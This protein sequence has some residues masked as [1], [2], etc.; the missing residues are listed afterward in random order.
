LIEAVSESKSVATSW[1]QKDDINQEF[2]V[3]E[4]SSIIGNI[5]SSDAG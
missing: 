2:S 1:H 3:Q 5:F 4:F